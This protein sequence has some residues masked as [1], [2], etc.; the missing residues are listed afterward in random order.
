[1]DGPGRISLLVKGEPTSLHAAV[2]DELCFIGREAMTNA[3]RHSGATEIVIELTY[4]DQQ[5]QLQC[6]DNG[7]GVS[8]E[9]VRASARQGHWG[10]IGMR[11]RAGGLGCT[12][13]F[14]S[15]VG[16][17]TVV[18]VRVPAKKAYAR[19]SSAPW[20]KLRFGFVGLGKTL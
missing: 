4:E 14:S 13:D 3:I 5:L 20:W 12:F 9:M 8:Q 7:C 18:T 10:I 17:G 11:E 6:R 15:T 19:T 16:V 1:M 2:Q